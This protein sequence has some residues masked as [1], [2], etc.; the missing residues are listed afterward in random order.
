MVVHTK[1]L[2][3]SL[4][5]GDQGM[6]PSCVNCR[7][8]HAFNE[9]DLLTTLVSTPGEL[10]QDLVSQPKPGIAFDSTILLSS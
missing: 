10:L 6:N 1:A 2:S 9:T 3:S 8:I 7:Q 5:I 4:F